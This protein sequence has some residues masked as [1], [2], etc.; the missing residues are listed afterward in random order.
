[1][2]THTYDSDGRLAKITSGGSDDA[3][4]ETLYVYDDAGRILSITNTADRDRTDFRYDERGRKAAIKR[5]HPKT[6]E[7]LRNSGHT[8]SAWDAALIGFGVPMGGTVTTI[9]DEKDRPVELQTT[10]ADGCPVSRIVRTYNASGLVS[11]EKPIWENPASTFLDKFPVEQ[12][13]EL[14]PERVQSLSKAMSVLLGGK[15][16]AGTVYTYDPQ[17]RATTIRERNMAFERTTTL[18]YNDHGDKA[19]ES[20]A[21]IDNCVVPIGVPHSIDDNGSLIPTNVKSEAPAPPPFLREKHVVQY[22]YEYD[23]HGNWTRQTASAAYDGSQS[24]RVRKR[25]LTYY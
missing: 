15:A 1:V 8:C 3:A 19:D 6:L 25:K 4:T 18:A 5:F 23:D 10:D 20:T 17:G 11:E 21:T 12:R 14:T 24:S 7:Q 2:I 16:Q 22:S 13:D 9:Y